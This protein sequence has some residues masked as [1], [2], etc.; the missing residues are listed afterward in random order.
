MGAR[1]GGVVLVPPRRLVRLHRHH[2]VPGELAGVPVP[3]HQPVET[4]V[5]AHLRALVRREALGREHLVLDV[6]VVGR[7]VVDAGRQRGHR[8]EQLGRRRGDDPHELVAGR[9]DTGGRG[10][11][12]DDALADLGQVLPTVER[13]RRPAEA[14]PL[15][16]RHGPGRRVPG[17]DAERR[18][19][20]GAGSLDQVGE[21]RGAVATTPLPG[22][23]ADPQ[24]GE[25]QVVVRRGLVLGPADALLPHPRE[26]GG[27]R[28]AVPAVPQLQPHPVGAPRVLPRR[29]VAA[30]R[31]LRLGEVPQVPLG[32]LVGA[33]GVDGD[34]HGSR[35]RRAGHVTAHGSRVPLPAAAVRPIF[36]RR[37]G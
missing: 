15:G 26:V 23:H 21:H 11:V 36:R 2:G 9:A 25:G 14:V 6:E 12:R 17:V 37:S 20:L 16:E 13:L 34:H 29:V 19:A 7:G 28:L 30:H 33:I 4:V 3:C 24:P 10:Q 8:R 32:G 5:G 27:A 22:D 1:H 31:L 35:H 18:P